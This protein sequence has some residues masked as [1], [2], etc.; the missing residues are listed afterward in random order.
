MA[1]VPPRV[2]RLGGAGAEVTAA[3]AVAA[4]AGVM[5]LVRGLYP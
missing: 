4:V 5:R 1:D 3:A 2:M